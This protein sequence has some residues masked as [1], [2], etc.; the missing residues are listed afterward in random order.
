MNAIVFRFLCDYLLRNDSLRSL[1]LSDETK[2][3]VNKTLLFSLRRDS[4]FT[5][6]ECLHVLMILL[7]CGRE[8]EVNSYSFYPPNET[9]PQFELPCLKNNKVIPFLLAEFK[10]MLWI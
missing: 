8:E 5:R 1:L 6:R 2:V 10:K 4:P 3:L 7:F 9:Y